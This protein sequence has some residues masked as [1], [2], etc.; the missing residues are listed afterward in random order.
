M[1]M[2]AAKKCSMRSLLEQKD[3]AERLLKESEIVESRDVDSETFTMAEFRGVLKKLEKDKLLWPSIEE[4]SDAQLKTW[5]PADKLKNFLSYTM[6]AFVEVAEDQVAKV[7]LPLISDKDTRS[8]GF[9]WHIHIRQYIS[10]NYA[11]SDRFS[12][13]DTGAVIIEKRGQKFLIQDDHAYPHVELAE[14]RKV[15]KVRGA[16]FVLTKK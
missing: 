6:I 4:F 14:G 12:F 2:A 10:E 11:E 13:V 5:R 3:M 9:S 8:G 7:Y 1:S 15:Y 16:H